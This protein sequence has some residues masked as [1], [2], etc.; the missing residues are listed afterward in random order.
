MTHIEHALT[1]VQD[2]MVVGLGTGR[3][4][5]SF[6]EGLGQKVQAGLK[7][8]GVATSEKSAQLAAGLGIQLAT[9]AEVDAKLDLCVD[10]TDEF[11]PELN[12][13]KGLG[14]AL[15]REKLSRRRRRNWSFW[16]GRTTSP[17][18]VQSDRSVN[19]ACC[20]WRSFRL[21]WRSVSGD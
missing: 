4:A 9:L 5:S 17:S 10:G 14:G 7:V 1:Y 8:V 12:L 15:V 2:G 6:I 19:G 11:D 20:R 13:I 18:S 21:R 16:S 3:A